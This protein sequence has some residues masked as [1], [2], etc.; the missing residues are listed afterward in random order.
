[1]EQFVV[2]SIKLTA[3]KSKE[4]GKNSGN[5]ASSSLFLPIVAGCASRTNKK[6]KPLESC[7]IPTV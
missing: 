1:M 4:F 3:L 6:E 2:N 5:P 7:W